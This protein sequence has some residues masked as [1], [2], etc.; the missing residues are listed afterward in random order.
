MCSA[1]NTFLHVQVKLQTF[2]K[3]VNVKLWIQLP[4]CSSA[5][6][7]PTYLIWEC[8]CP[9]VALYATIVFS[10][11]NQSWNNNEWAKYRGKPGC[12][13]DVH[14]FLHVCMTLTGVSMTQ[15][16]R[17]IQCSSGTWL[18]DQKVR[19]SSG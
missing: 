8:T 3:T 18:Q 7:E 1:T 13:Y 14:S 9:R 12:K 10:I 17:M 5:I 19:Q 11:H 6:P 16:Q 2:A 4:I 15:P